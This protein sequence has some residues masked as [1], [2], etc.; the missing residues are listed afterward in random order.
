[1]KRI[2]V[3]GAVLVRDDKILAAQRSASMSLPLMWESP[4]G[5]IEQ[6]ETRV[7][8]LRREL[9]EELLCDAVVGEHV[10]TTEHDY[11]FGTVILSTYFCTLNGADPQITEHKEIRWVAVD[12]L[13][14]LDWAPADIP[15]VQKIV[16]QLGLKPS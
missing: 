16:H 15:A 8:A 5:K 9:E 4:G 11:D 13:L 10:E 14:D 3:V 1:M 2:N 12:H 6:N 7:E